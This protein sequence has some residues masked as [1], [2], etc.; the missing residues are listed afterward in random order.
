[1]TPES[2]QIVTQL[3]REFYAS[4]ASFMKEPVNITQG[5]S[6]SGN[7]SM[8]SWIDARQQLNYL[9]VYA[10]TAPDE[11]V[12]ERP[13][14]LR[15][16]ANKNADLFALSKLRRGCQGLNRNW[17]F[18]L[19][20]LPEEILAFLPWIVSL[21]TFYEKGIAGVP[22]PPYPLEP[23]DQSEVLRFQSAWTQRAGY[24]LA[25]SKR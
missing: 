14:L 22:E 17:H 23:A 5:N 2:I 1:M 13:F 7:P 21:V 10:H 24:S 15:V 12:P 25:L 3:R 20:L 11:L 19:T 16:S 9:C 8:V 6:S 4:F 18:E